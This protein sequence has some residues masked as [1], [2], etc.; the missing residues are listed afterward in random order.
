LKLHFNGYLLMFFLINAFYSFTFVMAQTPETQP[1]K[2]QNPPLLSN[3]Q[4][5]QWATSESGFTDEL[6]DYI[7]SSC[8]ELNLKQNQTD[9]LQK[10][11]DLCDS[12]Q[13]SEK[14]LEHNEGLL[15]LA[16]SSVPHKSMKGKTNEKVTTNLKMVLLTQASIEK[17]KDIARKAYEICKNEVGTVR[18]ILGN[19]DEDVLVLIQEGEYIEQEKMD[20]F[21][22]KQEHPEYEADEFAEYS[23]QTFIGSDSYQKFSDRKLREFSDPKKAQLYLDHYESLFETRLL[24]AFN[25]V[26]DPEKDVKK[27]ADK[28]KKIDEYQ[29][30]I[31]NL[32]K[33]IY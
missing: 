17:N 15:D 3:D 18:E 8:S 31:T 24:L 4:W 26:F 20:Y 19:K 29:S 12:M 21:R 22:K 27:I 33:E 25:L 30:K 28:Q 11:F 13:Q 6:D 32:L 1:T 2:E 14:T 9:E 10:F 5:F 16:N 23:Y 7:D